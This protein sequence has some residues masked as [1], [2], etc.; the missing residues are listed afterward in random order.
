MDKL[1]EKIKALEIL[2]I[3]D[4]EK[5][6]NTVSPILMLEPAVLNISSP[7]HVVGDIHG[8]FLDLLKIFDT[9]GYPPGTQYLMLGDYVDRGTHSLETILLLFVLKCEYPTRL[10]L[11]RGN[12]ESREL[13]KIYGFYDEILQKYGDARV[14]RYIQIAF[15]VLPIGAVVDGRYLCTHGGISP[16]TLSINNIK[17]Q[18]TGAISKDVIWSDPGTVG[19]I[20][21]QRGVGYLYGSDVTSNFLEVNGLKGLIRSHQLVHDGFRFHFDEKNVLTVWSAPDYC[22][23]CSNKGAVLCIDENHQVC[24]NS[25]TVFPSKHNQS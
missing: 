20:K 22:G 4:I 14:W 1:L 11:I 13:T 25:F 7:V 12:H 21:S 18:K 10:F 16:L 17:K 23:R 5:I 6:V 15:D 9:L 2:S 3:A 24:E 19:W 8:Q